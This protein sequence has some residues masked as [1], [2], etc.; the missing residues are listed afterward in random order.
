MTQRR[1]LV[2]GATK[3]LGLALVEQYLNGGWAVAATTIEPSAGLAQL[4]AD[5]PE[6]LSVHP[7]DITDPAG[8]R[9]VREAL[10][11]LELDVL[12]IVSGILPSE[13]L[14]IWEYADD[15]VLKVLNINAFAA[16]HLATCMEPLVRKGGLFA[17]TSSGMGSM[18]RNDRGG[19]DLYRI[20]KAALNMLVRS[21]AATRAGPDR[22]VL[23][24]CPGWVKTDMG[25][26]EATVEVADSVAGIYRL[27]CEARPGGEPASF[28]EYSGDRVPW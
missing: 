8:I 24:I 27:I 4:A 25:G 16:L 10:D 17:F 1:V 7:L 13:D 19:A 12:H 11:G 28:V 9:A 23:L 15:Q 18:S 14:P 2:V 21:F 26:P 6:K 5:H 3:G 20:S 22:T